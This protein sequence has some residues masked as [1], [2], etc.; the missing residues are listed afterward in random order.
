M[1]CSKRFCVGQISL[2]D[3]SSFILTR[4]CTYTIVSFKFHI[5]STSSCSL[6]V[7][8]NF[9]IIL[10]LNTLFSFS[11][12]FFPSHFVSAHALFQLSKDSNIQTFLYFLFMLL[13]IYLCAPHFC[14]CFPAC[15][16][17]IRPFTLR[18]T[19]L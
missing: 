16:N 3:L 11:G 12:N 4:H 17:S 8:Q 18:Q 2:L 15:K 5:F 14:S 1:I 7:F 13:M 19:I 9:V 10:P 6:F